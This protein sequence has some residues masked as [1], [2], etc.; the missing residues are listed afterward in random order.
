MRYRVIANSLRRF[1]LIEETDGVLRTTWPDDATWRHL[2]A[3]DE[4]RSLLPDLSRRLEAYF[5]GESVDFSDL[6]TPGS[7]DFHRRCWEA[8]RSISR[9]EVRSYR[10]LAELAGGDSGASRAAGQA[11]RRNRMPVIIPC[12]R[13]ISS[14]GD[15]LGFAGS[16]DPA[17]EMIRLK[18]R[19]LELEGCSFTSNQAQLFDTECAEFSISEEF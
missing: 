18:R 1:V 14:S 19:L 2:R 16:N 9:G 6:P 7:P 11:M 12:H 4:D 13:V 5:Q 3:E 10:Q 17:G 8:C 15:L